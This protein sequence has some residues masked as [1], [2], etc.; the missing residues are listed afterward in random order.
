MR[1]HFMRFAVLAVV[2]CLAA[3]IFTGSA[4]AQ[5]QGPVKITLDDAI[6]L[7]LQRNHTLLAT[8]T[9]IQQ[10]EDQEITANLRPNPV[11]LG[12]AQF[13][14]IFNPS[15]FDSDYFDESAPVRSRPQL[16]VRAR[17]KAPSTAC[18]RPRMPRR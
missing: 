12:D 11:L 18:R 15:Q 5:A 14:P 4:L 1:M 7:A 9:Q 10:S 2:V 13:L 3:A 6:Q 8:R 17:Q 16:S